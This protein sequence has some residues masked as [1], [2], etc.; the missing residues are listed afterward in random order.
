MEKKLI[1]KVHV[2]INPQDISVLNGKAGDVVMIP[3]S[4]TVEGEIFNGVVRPGGV[5]VQRTNLSKIRHMCA[6]YMLEGTDNTGAPC[7]IF[8][9][10]NGWFDDELPPSEGGFK[11][12]PTFL[13]D[14]EAMAPYLHSNKFIGIG[15]PEGTGVLISLYEVIE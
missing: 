13:T 3:F 8:V 4:G 9:D 2:K 11:T 7:K 14:S 5:D 12:V 6:R 10:N 15:T 1:M